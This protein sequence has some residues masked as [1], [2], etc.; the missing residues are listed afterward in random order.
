MLWFFL[1][2]KIGN[3][4]LL[5]LH[6]ACSMIICHKFDKTQLIILHE[7]NISSIAFPRVSNL[8]HHRGS[9]LSAM[10]VILTRQSWALLSVFCDLAWVAQH[11][12][13]WFL[14]PGSRASFSGSRLLPGSW[15]S[16]IETE[17]GKFESCLMDTLWGAHQYSIHAV[18]WEEH[19]RETKWVCKFPDLVQ[20]CRWRGE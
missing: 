6:A 15:S 8:T 20:S 5:V 16:H 19:V 17:R 12:S 10:T 14:C 7:I 3:L 9:K 2:F 4:A 11:G 13:W 18:T 1:Y